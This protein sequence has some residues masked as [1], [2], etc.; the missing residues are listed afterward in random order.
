MKRFLLVNSCEWVQ[1]SIA[2]I[3]EQAGGYELQVASS[4]E[5]TR[6]AIGSGPWDVIFWDYY[7]EGAR[8]TS[9]LLKLA[10]A[11]FPKAKMIA[12]GP[13]H[14]CFPFQ[15][16]DGCDDDLETSTHPEA[17]PKLVLRLSS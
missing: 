8:T 10:R 12:F 3:L 4:I 6:A 7:L 5:G 11:R 15:R 14:R 2:R 16:R 1:E 9:E 17:L 13:D